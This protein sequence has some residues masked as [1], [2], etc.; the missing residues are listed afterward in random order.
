MAG[1]PALHHQGLAS[2]PPGAYYEPQKTNG[3][4]IC[5]SFPSA[6]SFT[7]MRRTRPE[8]AFSRSPREACHK[9]HPSPRLRDA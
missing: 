8:A 3:L 4:F 9:A 5:F 6:A 7:H 1:N 2:F